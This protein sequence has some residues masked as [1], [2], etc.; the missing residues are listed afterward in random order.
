MRIALAC[1]YAWD[2]PGG[3]QVHVAQLAERLRGR[4]HR[5][6]VV[7]PSRA[8]I[9]D[10][11]VVSIG[12]TIPVPVNGSIA[13][14]APRPAAA[15]R[16]R[17][18]LDDFGPDVVHAHEPF[19]PSASMFAVRWGGAPVVATFHAYA[20][21]SPLL[22]AAVPFLRPVWDRL[23]V[24]VAVSEAAR[25]FVSR[26]FRGEIRVVPNGV[27]VDLFRDARPADLP[28]GRRVLFVNR[29]DPRK[30][31]AVM[32]RAF[33]LLLGSHPDALLVV[34]GDGKE[35][36]AVSD[37]PRPARD[38]VVMLG[39]VPHDLLPPYHAAC[40]VFAA[41]AVG[42]ESFG[43]VLVEAMAAG[44]PV[45]ASDIPGYREVVRRGDDGLLVPPRDTAALAAALRRVLDDHEL[46]ERLR[47]AGR[48]RSA[49]YSWETVTRQ[50]ETAYEEAVGGP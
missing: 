17:H 27:D 4:G 9:D 26:R 44:L 15:R 32:V 22:A 38:R 10:P 3:V 1:P 13:P 29:L 25:R 31:F 34:A 12:G 11:H 28:P 50:V 16:T 48:A 8:R 6:L 43:I 24:R 7:A 35:R 21:R 23:T 5:V 47:D 20:D 19:V 18:A 39:N 30:G 45:V 2:A 37:L 41:P 14:I 42:R 49:G 33:E 46:A 40:E 36:A